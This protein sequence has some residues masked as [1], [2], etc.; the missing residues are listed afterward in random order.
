MDEG[1]MT[2]EELIKE[3]TKL[4]QR[5]SETDSL[6]KEL[7]ETNSFLSNII[8]SS[9]AISLIS[10]DLDQ[11]I[12]YWNHGAENI[13]GYKS[14]EMV[15][16]HKINKLYAEGESDKRIAEI[17]SEVFSKRRGL[18]VEIREVTKDERDLWINMTL[19][20]RVDENN[21]LIGILGIGE[22]IT[23]R[24]IAEEERNRSMEKL[25]K[26]LE[27]I[28]NAMVITVETKDPYTAGH[29]R[30]TAE[31]ATAIAKD[32][33]LPEEEIESIH[34]AGIIHDLGKIAIPG[35]I[36][37]KPGSLN[38]IQV[39]MIRTHPSVG[40]EILKN[41]DFPWPIAQIMLEHH[42]RVDGSGY[43]TGISGENIN[44]KSKIIAVADVVEAIIS[45]RPYR[46]ALGIK[47]ALEEIK[48]NSGTL[49]DPAVVKAC[50]KLFKKNGFK[51][52]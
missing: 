52:E 3:L 41:I 15:G 24:K 47:K 25:K 36:L 42:E 1:N 34:M 6:E 49:Y 16:K 33:G 40:Y 50:Y 32:L 44:F 4:R 12:V 27:G 35:E 14:E 43:P 51:F 30:R 2:K 17:R 26:A 10:T 45:H 11:N 31:L 8:E 5:L 18:S 19:T 48:V 20:P 39:S 13:F 23:E 38:E 28:I 9:S 29:Q 37:S 21:N 7:R 46:A 22:D